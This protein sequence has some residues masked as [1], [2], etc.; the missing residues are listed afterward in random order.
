MDFS[1]LVPSRDGKK[2]FAVGAQPRTELLR[3]DGKS[4][5]FGPS[6]ADCRSP[7]WHSPDGQWVTYV[8]IPDKTLW[9]SRLDGSER[10]QLTDPGKVWANS[11]GK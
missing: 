2:F 3:S 11:G 7:T 8:T 4:G 9:R 1:E 5:L 10:L 6:S